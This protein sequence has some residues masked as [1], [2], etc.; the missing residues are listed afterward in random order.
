[1]GNPM[2]VKGTRWET[3]LVRAANWLGVPAYRP[4]QRGAHDVGD[5]HGVS[6]FV[7]QAKDDRSFNFSG[8]LDGPKGVTVQAVH[9]GE[10]Y[11]AV[12]VKR[13]RRSVGEAYTVMRYEDFVRVVS[14]L[15]RA[16]SMLETEAPEAFADHS[17]LTL[18]ELQTPFPKAADLT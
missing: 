1:M 6:P 8:W 11:G 17:A 10:Q 3:L 9:A 14:R 2:K 13:A 7:I 5:I 15:R 12:V 16:E 4:A 18:A